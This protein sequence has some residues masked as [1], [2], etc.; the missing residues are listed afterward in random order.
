MATART[1]KNET[2]KE[3]PPPNDEQLAAIS[4]GN[5]YACVEAGPGSGKSFVLVQRFA[6]L[7]KEGVSPDD[8]LSLSFTRTAA[9]NLRDRVEA[10]VGKLSINRTAGALTFHSLALSFATEERD[11]FPYELAE[12]PLA[13]EPVAG[14]LSGDAARR[15]ELDPRVLRPLV[16]LWKRKRLRPAALIKDFE[17]RVDAKNLKLALAYKDYQKRLKEQGLV[18]FDGLILEM[19]EVLDKKSAVREKWVRDFIQVD[20]AQDLSKIEWDLVKLLSGRSIVAVGDVSQGIYSFRGSDS[21][22]FADMEEI[23]PGTKTLYLSCNYRSSP[24]IIDFIRPISA[25]K[26]QAEKFHTQNPSGPS[27]V[28]KG[29][30]SPVD[31]AAWVVSEVKKE[32]E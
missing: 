5:G 8:I 22:L 25:T 16:S 31:E 10:Q 18:D 17:N 11:E 32:S 19:V 26:E 9:K 7:I 13:S 4:F 21:R 15:Y 24:E 23:F 30:N 28:V 29:F 6:R 14:K 12:F 20:E 2:K 1:K 27:P 3:S